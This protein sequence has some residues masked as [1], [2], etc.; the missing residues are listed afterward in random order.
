VTS[1]LKSDVNTSP[2]VAQELNIPIHVHVMTAEVK[3]NKELKQEGV[4]WIDRRQVAQQAGCCAS[5][6]GMRN[7]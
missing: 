2:C 7:A 1:E 3:S 4:I 5:T 6:L